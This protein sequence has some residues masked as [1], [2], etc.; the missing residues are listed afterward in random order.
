VA[1]CEIVRLLGDAER[2]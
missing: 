1:P 2:A